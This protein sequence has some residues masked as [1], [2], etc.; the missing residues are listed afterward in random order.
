MPRVQMEI[1]RTSLLAGAEAAQGTT[2]I[3]DVFRAFTTAAYA[4]A[5]GAREIW[6]VKAIEDAFALRRE[7]PQALLIGERD[8]RPLEGFDYGNSPSI[9]AQ[10]D[11][12]DRII[13]QRTSA[14]TQGVIAARQAEEILLGSLVCAEATV[15]HIQKHRPHL[16]MLVAMGTSG[17]AV[18][19]EDELCAGYLDARLRGLRP[20]PHVLIQ[21]VENLPAAQEVRS[22]RLTHF[23]PTDLDCC[24]SL[25]EFDFAMVVARR[26]KGLMARAVPP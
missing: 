24:L 15:R 13:I 5:R 6:L 17:L 7:L 26:A 20:D 14:G 9:I 4:F 1:R 22:G 23:P 2:V 21:R 11:L 19:A 3:I 8:G 10:L 18:S 16:V 25:D 12:A